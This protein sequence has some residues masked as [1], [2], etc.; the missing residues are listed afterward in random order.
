MNDD[1]VEITDIDFIK[2]LW[3]GTEDSN[4][5]WIGMYGQSPVDS[6]TEQRSSVADVRM[7]I[8]ICRVSG[9]RVT[10]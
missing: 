2:Q 6:K 9:L 3:V 1:A 8:W 10:R 5:I 4:G 7:I